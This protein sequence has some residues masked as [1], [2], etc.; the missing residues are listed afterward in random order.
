[1]AR[2]SKAERERKEKRDRMRSLRA[3][4]A[5]EGLVEFRI[6]AEI[7]VVRTL[8][9]AAEQLGIPVGEVIDRHAEVC[10]PNL[11]LSAGPRWYTAPGNEETLSATVR[12]TTRDLLGS[13]GP[14][15]MPGD[16]V[17][18]LTLAACS[19]ELDERGIPWLVYVHPGA[20]DVRVELRRAHER[21]GLRRPR[22][23]GGYEGELYCKYE[24]K[25]RHRDYLRGLA[26]LHVC[27]PKEA[28]EAD[29]AEAAERRAELRRQHEEE[30]MT[31]VILAEVRPLDGLRA[32]PGGWGEQARRDLRGVGEAWTPQAAARRA[33]ARDR[34]AEFREAMGGY[35]E[36]GES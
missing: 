3:R 11:D 36:G 4:R 35:A 21:G 1:M 20:P 31:R 30:T 33:A 5:E 22:Y 9:A 15:L 23:A 28:D 16:V 17:E 27:P 13:M 8:R 2:M 10:G 6:E 26:G 32:E 14:L 19:T 29:M 12:T 25:M 34:W 7:P 24:A 18:W